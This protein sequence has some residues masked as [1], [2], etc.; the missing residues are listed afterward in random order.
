MVLAFLV[1]SFLNISSPPLSNDN[2]DTSSYNSTTIQAESNNTI[3]VSWCLSN[4]GTDDLPSVCD[5]SVAQYYAEI[6]ITIAISLAIVVARLL[7]KFVVIG[8]AKFQRYTSI[9]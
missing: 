1:I 7:T 8:L 2:I 6:A 5:E 4:I 9:T 3:V